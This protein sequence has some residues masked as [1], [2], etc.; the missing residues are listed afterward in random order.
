MTGKL[1]AA[2]ES[3]T[4]GTGTTPVPVRA[5]VCGVLVALP[6]RLSE[7]VRDPPAVGLKVTEIVHEALMASDVPQ[8][9]VWA[10]DDA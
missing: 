2:V 5:T 10:K 9:L 3:V 8:L 4:T 1:S 6:V 7:A